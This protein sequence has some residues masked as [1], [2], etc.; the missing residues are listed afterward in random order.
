ML[1]PWW[2]CCANSLSEAIDI[3]WKTHCF[4]QIIVSSKVFFA[5]YGRRRR[6]DSVLS[7]KTLNDIR[8]AEKNPKSDGW[9]SRG[10]WDKISWQS[11]LFAK[12]EIW[13]L[14]L[15]VFYSDH[16]VL[17]LRND[18][19]DIVHSGCFIPSATFV[20]LHLLSRGPWVQ[21]GGCTHWHFL[22]KSL[23]SVWC[24]GE[25]GN[26]T[27]GVRIGIP[28]FDLLP[29][30]SVLVMWRAERRAYLLTFLYQIY[31]YLESA[32]GSKTNITSCLPT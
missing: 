17:F 31:T 1:Y 26:R 12:T 16:A 29:L 4:A 15:S 27:V 5:P 32:A 30:I 20:C 28:L 18:N 9:T 8:F 13:K 22:S 11:N 14:N 21:N 6:R 19:F 10:S 23:N 25:I 24:L 3:E 2:A 7:L